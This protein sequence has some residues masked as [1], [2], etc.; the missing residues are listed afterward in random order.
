V[1]A[2]ITAKGRQILEDVGAAPSNPIEKRF[3]Q[4]GQE[5]L[6]VLIEALDLIRQG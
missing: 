5:Q 6:Q 1:T 4:L 2:R 3:S